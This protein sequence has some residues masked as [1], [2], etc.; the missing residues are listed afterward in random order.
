MHVSQ[1]QG[2]YGLASS[3]ALVADCTCLEQEIIVHEMPLRGLQTNN[4][5]HA[6]AHTTVG[7][8]GDT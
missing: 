3:L 2:C 1:Q 4:H 5:V 7:K 8:L 6:K